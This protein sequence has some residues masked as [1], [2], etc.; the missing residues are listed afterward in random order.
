[1]SQDV[2]KMGHY[3]R[4]QVKPRWDLPLPYYLNYWDPL[5]QGVSGHWGAWKGISKL[6]YR[7]QT[8][9][10][11]EMLVSSGSQGKPGPILSPH[12]PS[13]TLTR[14]LHPPS[15]AICAPTVNFTT[16]ETSCQAFF[17]RVNLYFYVKSYHYL[18]WL[19]LHLSPHFTYWPPST[20]H[21]QQLELSHGGILFEKG[22]PDN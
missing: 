2:K 14:P 8:V 20:F 4:F 12:S 3:Q 11:V 17:P 10:V 13:T 7:W 22:S 9:G 16:S 15:R 18:L 21:N 1:M 5:T 19:N 6:H